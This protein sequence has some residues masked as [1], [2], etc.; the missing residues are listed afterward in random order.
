MKTLPI[1]I[2]RSIFAA[3]LFSSVAFGETVN[4]SAEVLRDKIRGGLLGQILG[5]LNGLPHEMKYTVEPGKVSGYVPALPR[6]AWT[7]DDTDFEW[8]YIKVMEDEN[9]LLLSPERI[10]RLWKERINQRIWCSNQFARQLMDIGLEP[11]LT[12]RPLL[13]PWAEFNV[14]GQFLCE[15]FGLI[16]PALPRRA[17][18]IGLNYTRVAIGGEPAQTTQFFTAMIALAYVESNI[19]VL[20]DHGVA[21]IDPNSVVAQIVREVRAWHRENP[22][23][24]QATRARL[25]AKYARHNHLH[26]DRNG[27]ELNTGSIVGA[28]LYGRGEFVPTL[29]LAFNFGWDADCNAATVGTILGVAKGYRWMLAQGWQI[30]DRY[31]NTVTPNLDHVRD[32]S[33]TMPSRENMP[34][35]ETITSFADRLI[36]LAERVVIEQG[37]RRLLVEGR[38]VYE[39]PR[40]KPA[41]IQRME[42]PADEVANMKATMEP[43]VR[44]AIAGSAQQQELARAAYLAICLGLAPSLRQQQPEKWAGAIAAL[45][46]YPKL[47][48]AIF[49]HAPVPMGEVLREKALAAGLAKPAK[50]QKLW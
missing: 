32:L 36:D 11:P 34:T 26:R 1:I 20:L 33:K 39:I 6:G 31:T 37:G 47:V 30:V 42:S 48:Q 27:F 10:T 9:V 46:Q 5:N 25:S 15:T 12:G 16:A 28:M 45:G 35:D 43:W 17:A 4:I 7:D 38:P 21:A 40:Q 22:N 50:S 23:D 49:N 2:L 14:S 19:N 24:W 44:Q 3:V 41:C 13:N 29:T 8:V 18:E